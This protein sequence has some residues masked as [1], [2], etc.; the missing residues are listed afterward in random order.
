[1][2]EKI[3]KAVKSL[4]P[5]SQS[6][7]PFFRRGGRKIGED[8]SHSVSCDRIGGFYVKESRD[9]SRLREIRAYLRKNHGFF[10]GIHKF[11]S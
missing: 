2:F 3:R 6:Q 11:S 8:Y 5:A 7:P 1:M 4:S 10:D 9:Y